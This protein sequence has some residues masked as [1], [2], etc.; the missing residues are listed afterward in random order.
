MKTLNDLK[1]RDLISNAKRDRTIVAVIVF[2]ALITMGTTIIGQYINNKALKQNLYVIDQE[3]KAFRLIL[4]EGNISQNR[5]F[6]AKAFVKHVLELLF[7]ISPDETQIAY[8]E[9]KLTYLAGDDSIQ[10]II[11]WFKE[12]RLYTGIIATRT[13]QNVF[14]NSQEDIIVEDSGRQGFNVAVKITT[15]ISRPSAKEEQIRYATCKLR[16]VP[17][18]ENNAHGFLVEKLVMRDPKK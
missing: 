10:E 3:G 9:Q 14:I 7:T 6:E 15:I 5:I 17:R 11:E 4:E 8:N 12:N 1:S 18:S 13:S 2:L 16:Q